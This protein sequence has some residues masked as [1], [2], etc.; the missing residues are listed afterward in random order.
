MRVEDR[1]TVD[2]VHNAV[3]QGGWNVV[4]DPRHYPDYAEGYYAVFIT[5]PDGIRWEIAHIPT[6]PH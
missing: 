4:H 6:P 1:A 3:L 5:D 2:A